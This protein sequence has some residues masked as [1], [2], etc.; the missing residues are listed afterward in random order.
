M[1]DRLHTGRNDR[2]FG[3][4]I[5]NGIVSIP[6]NVK[7]PSRPGKPAPVVPEGTIEQL[8]ASI[9][10]YLARAERGGLAPAIHPFFGPLSATTWAKFHYRHFE[11]HL[12]Q[13]GV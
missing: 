6:H 8:R 3:P 5:A 9:D 13:F 4:L 7:I 12:S 10:E 2:V 1:R 11:H